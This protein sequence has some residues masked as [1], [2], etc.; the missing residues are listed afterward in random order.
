MRARLTAGL[1]ALCL[2]A[3]A[4]FGQGLLVIDR[5]RLLT[6]SAPALQLRALESRQR[7]S[8]RTEMDRIRAE[9]EAE[10]AEI[11][12]LRGQIGR[13]EF[14]TRVRAFDARVREARRATQKMGEGLQGEFETARRALAAALAPVLQDILKERDADIMVDISSVLAARPGVDVTIEAMKRFAEIEVDFGLIPA[15][16]GA[17]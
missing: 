7:E 16:D 4:A 10:E 17:E 1:L 11:A 8:L 15:G 9:L 6:E 3:G 5:Q 2:T 12:G 14:Q 13:E